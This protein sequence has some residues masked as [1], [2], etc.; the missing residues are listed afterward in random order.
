MTIT[1]RRFAEP[2]ILLLL[3]V[4]ATF[5]LVFA[6]ATFVRATTDQTDPKVGTDIIIT[7]CLHEGSDTDSFVLVGVTEKPA[8]GEAA[9]VV[10]VPFAI[11]LLDSNKGLKPLVGQMVDVAGRI[12]KREDKHGKITIDILPSN[13]RSDTVRVETD[14]TSLKTKEYAV[15]P[16]YPGWVTSESQA[17][18]QLRRPVYKLDVKAVSAAAGL[19]HLGPDCQ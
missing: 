5:A 15:G 9:P 16:P 6:G 14:D 4:M 18:L 8:I 11:Y 10:P 1:N 19:G 12:T 13:E 3:C 2:R 7:G 17:T